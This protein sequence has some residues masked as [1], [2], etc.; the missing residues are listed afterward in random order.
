MNTVF[1][2]GTLRK[3]EINHDLVKNFQ[4]IDVDSVEGFIML[5]FGDYPVIFESSS[6]ENVFVEIY[7]VDNYT[8]KMIDL[9]EEY[10]GE[11]HCCNLYNRL[12]VKSG[13]GYYGFIYAG[14]SIEKFPGAV[15]IPSGDWKSR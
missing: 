4:L 10:H 8:L 1:V 13:K 12:I 14:T 15:L 2:Y 11:S 3:D 7:S 5:D 9:L 6:R